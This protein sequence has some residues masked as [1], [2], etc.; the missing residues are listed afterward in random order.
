MPENQSAFDYVK[1]MFGGGSPAPSKTQQ[2]PVNQAPL[3][4]EAEQRA[5]EE[6]ARMVAA[7][8][9]PPAPRQ[10]ITSPGG[11]GSIAIPENPE[12]V[13]YNWPAKE[14]QSKFEENTAMRAEAKAAMAI[15]L[16]GRK[17]RSL[18]AHVRDAD[19]EKFQALIDLEIPP[20]KSF[21]DENPSVRD[22]V[23][24]VMNPYHKRQ[25]FVEALRGQVSL[26][27]NTFK[28]YG[29]DSNEAA[30]ELV[31]KLMGMLK[32]Y[33]S[34]LA[35]TSDALS[36]AEVE[37]LTP[38]LNPYLFNPKKAL[39]VGGKVVGSD[40][41]K[42]KSKLEDLH[43]ILL[44]ESNSAFNTLAAMS[45]PEYAAKSLGF[46]HKRHFTENVVPRFSDKIPKRV[47]TGALDYAGFIQQRQALFEQELPQAQATKTQILNSSL[48]QE[49]K[50]RL[51]NGLR[52][53]FNARTGRDLD[54]PE[55]F[56][57]PRDK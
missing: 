27:N 19:K 20:V 18:P 45:S 50:Y 48:P 11:L 36:G 55:E 38:E 37:R 2:V 54:V 51:L 56:L 22:F 53:T 30:N 52:N 8:G 29:A 49:E 1:R 24:S 23:K 42:F 40:I 32:L 6:E 16:A 15:M 31:P 28:K 26:I 7:A 43:D 5:K 34:A 12:D 14:Q 21:D 41:Q 25:S 10:P 17:Y 33:N 47:A 4:P 39:Q 35:G 57:A 46:E 9:L 44:N 13:I 3:S